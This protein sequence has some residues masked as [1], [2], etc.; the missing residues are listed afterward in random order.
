[1]KHKTVSNIVLFCS[2]GRKTLLF[3][4]WLNCEPEANIYRTNDKTLNRLILKYVKGNDSADVTIIKQEIVSNFSNFLS[5]VYVVTSKT[6]VVPRT[7]LNLY[8]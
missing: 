7:L 3:L 8:F 2:V 4:L 5:G 1:M 6:A